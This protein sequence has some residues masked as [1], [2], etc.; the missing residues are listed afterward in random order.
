[1]SWPEF[2]RFAAVAIGVTFA[3]AAGAYF[4]IEFILFDL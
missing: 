1:V 4:L 2:A 3:I